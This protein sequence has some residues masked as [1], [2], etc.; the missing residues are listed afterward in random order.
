MR[1]ASYIDAVERIKMRDPLSNFLGVFE[2]GVVEF[3]LP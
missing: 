2:K 1:Y 3:S